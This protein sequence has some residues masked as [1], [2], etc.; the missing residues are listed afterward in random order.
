[1]LRRSSAPVLA[2]ALAM[3]LAAGAAAQPTVRLDQ[4]ARLTPTS[5]I[6]AQAGTAVALD[7]DRLAVGVPRDGDDSARPGVVVLYERDG[8][9]WAETARLDPPTAPTP[10]GA[11]VGL[12][13]ALDGDRL[14]VGAP[15]ED[16]DASSA[17]RA[18]LYERSGGGWSLTET[19]AAAAPEAFAGF[20]L[21]VA[22]DGDRA[23][24]G[25]PNEDGAGRVHAFE[26]T[27]GVW[28]A[29]DVFGPTPEAD[30]DQFGWSVALAGDVAFVGAV[31][32]DGPDGGSVGAV[33]RFDREVTGGAVTWDQG[34]TYG[35][36]AQAFGQAGWSLAMTEDRVAIGEPFF[37][38]EPGDNRG[39][40]WTL[41]RQ[42]GGSFFAFDRMIET[43]VLAGEDRFGYAVDVEGDRLVV[44]SL[45]SSGST[46]IPGVAYAFERGADAWSLVQTVEPVEGVADDFFGAAVS[47]D[48]DRVALGA[49]QTTVGGQVAAGAAYVFGDAFS[50]DAGD[51]APVP[52]ALV[53]QPPSP[54][55]TRGTAALR[56]ALAEAAALRVRVLDPLGRELAVLADGDA[57]AGWHEVSW[58]GAAAGV[59]VVEARSGAEVRHQR[60]TV[61]R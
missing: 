57:A 14:L 41:A 17:G 26:R 22:L 16:T 7:G 24:V 45:R 12:A 27:A 29:T 51:A 43:P 35:F 52:G 19:F 38:G 54:N 60:L 50:T 46:G 58:T 39:R 11:D 40:V 4:E 6:G 8:G 13:L 5:L 15:G 20:G 10:D 55:P 3:V 36:S 1:M 9:A 2:A 61:V 44:G 56:V 28:A 30:G 32:V 53:L 21:S 48:G 25:A 18:Y 42:A 47:L 59:Y 34:S 31:G 49:P 23:L 33:Y 37:D